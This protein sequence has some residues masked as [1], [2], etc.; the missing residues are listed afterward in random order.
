M[1]NESDSLNGCESCGNSVT[2]HYTNN[3]G[4]YC[5]ECLEEHYQYE[6]RLTQD[7]YIFSEKLSVYLFR[8]DGGNLKLSSIK[9]FKFTYLK[10]YLSFDKA[11]KFFM[12]N[13]AISAIRTMRSNRSWDNSYNKDQEDI[14]ISILKLLIQ[15]RR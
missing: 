5:N 9:Y 8:A 14:T 3:V 4:F 6:S 7:W 10:K 2:T 11:N 1:Y 13:R 15:N 12:I